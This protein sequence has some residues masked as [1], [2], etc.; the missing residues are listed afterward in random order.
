MSSFNSPGFAFD[1]SNESATQTVWGF[2]AGGGVEWAFRRNWTV[3][4]EYEY[5]GFHKT[6][7]GLCE[8]KTTPA[9]AVIAAVNC[10]S[11]AI[12]GIST[13]KVGFNY[14]FHWR[15]LTL[16]MRAK[17]SGTATPSSRTSRASTASP[18]TAG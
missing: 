14:L 4:A 10:T 5:L 18:W 11:T 17:P 15:A 3:K 2:A 12:S 8:R 1:L 16:S 9:G 6:V 13:A 7:A